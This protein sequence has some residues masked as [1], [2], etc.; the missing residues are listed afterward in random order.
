MSNSYKSFAVTISTKE[1]VEG[2]FQDWIQSFLKNQQFA[3]GV[4]ENTNGSRHAHFQ[5]WF[6]EPK[7]KGIFSRTLKRNIAKYAPESIMK[8]ALKV[9]IPYND[10]Y[11]EYMGKEIEEVILENLPTGNLER[12]YPS[13]EEQKKVKDAANAKDKRFHLWMNEF[14]EWWEKDINEELPSISDVALFLA[15]AM[16]SSKTMSVTTDKRIRIQNTK[17]L[18]LYI[19]GK[20]DI[21]EF[22][23]DEDY[24]F[25]YKRKYNKVPP[26]QQYQ[27]FLNV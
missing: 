11:I 27:K 9:K 2:A 15:D 1:Q 18:Y 16:F 17:C 19:L 21:K 14:I 12:F 25:Y 24:F 23:S 5:C 22:L 6:D 13:Q 3:Y 4:V 20:T 8:H 26:G 7:D 10:E